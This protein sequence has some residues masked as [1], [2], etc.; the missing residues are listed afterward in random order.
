MKKSYFK[1]LKSAV[2]PLIF[3]A[4]STNSS[5]LIGTSSNLSQSN[6]YV[7]SGTISIG[8]DIPT[9][10]RNIKDP[11]NSYLNLSFSETSIFENSAV[12]ASYSCNNFPDLQNKS[13]F[14]SSSPEIIKAKKGNLH[15]APLVGFFPLS[16]QFKPADNEVWIQIVK[17]KNVIEV[18]KGK[19]VLK[20]IAAEGD[21]KLAAGEYPLQHKQRNPLWYAPDEYFSRREL[22]VPPRGD[23]FRYRRGALGNYALYPTMDFVIHSGPF[24]S[25]EVGGLKVSEADLATVFVMMNVGTPIIVK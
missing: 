25:E 11:L 22:R 24:W 20:V 3:I 1:H 9:N 12:D 18:Y 10:L 5:E 7:K 17:E 15:F 23:H 13:Y 14:P 4:C 6:Q 16:L 8:F 19:E 21:I 2:I